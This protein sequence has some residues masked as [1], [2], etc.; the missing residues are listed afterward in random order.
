MRVLDVGRFVLELAWTMSACT[1]E[2]M[3]GVWGRV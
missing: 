1:R 2:I 3:F